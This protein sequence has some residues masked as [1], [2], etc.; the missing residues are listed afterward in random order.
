MEG[1]GVQ[2]YLIS[3]KTLTS[4]EY[5]KRNEKE[6]EIRILKREKKEKSSLIW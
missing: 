5:I 2:A 4:I 1:A 3:S 6:K